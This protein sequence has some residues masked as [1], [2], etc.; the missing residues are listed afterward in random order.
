MTKNKPR[1]LDGVRSQD[2]HIKKKFIANTML[3][4]N[5]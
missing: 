3:S 2:K 4:Y 1:Y 5:A